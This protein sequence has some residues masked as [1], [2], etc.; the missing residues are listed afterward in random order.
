MNLSKIR[1]ALV[2]AR[3]VIRMARGDECAPHERDAKDRVCDAREREL[4]EA[5]AEIDRGIN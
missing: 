4:T 2:S 1:Q 5:I 3:S